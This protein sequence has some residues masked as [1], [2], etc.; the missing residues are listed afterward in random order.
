[1]KI[2]HLKFHIN[3]RTCFVL[4]L[5]IMFVM[6]VSSNYQ[7]E[8]Y[9]FGG[10]GGT[11]NSTNY[12]IEG[13]LG[14][15]SGEQQS[16]NYK[17]N[18]GLTFV[19][20]AN[21]PTVT[22]TNSGNWY[23]R[24]LVEIGEEN[25]PSDTNYA[26]AI[27]DDNWVTTEYVQN[28]NTVGGTL[29][30]ED[31]QT[32]AAWGSGSG[33]YIIGLVP[34]TEYK[35]KVKATQGDF[36][37]SAWGPEATES[38]NPVTLSFDIDI[39]E[40]ANASSDAPYNLSI[41]SLTVGSVTTATDKVWV[42]VATNAEYGGFVYVYGTNNGLRSDNTNYTI[43]S[44]TANLAAAEDGYGIQAANS[45]GLTPV[46]PYDGS[47]DTVGAVN[48]TIREVFNTASSAVINGRGS[49]TI[50][51][52]TSATTPASNDYTDIL[53]LISSASF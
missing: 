31:W 39:G 48:A 3:A 47:S 28:D 7:L 49:M 35:V 43:T 37:E 29:G 6:P 24:L 21:V 45:S 33:E 25:N 52:K 2:S 4:P 20:N 53:T 15:T 46:S 51:V 27:S 36:T 32:Y 18:S 11:A 9:E 19:Q 30:A 8:S 41:G 13:V 50:K 16:T 17:A 23:N 42:D 34:D 40:D 22:L 44:A 26:I 12:G 14:E 5:F 10:G 38:T 1:M